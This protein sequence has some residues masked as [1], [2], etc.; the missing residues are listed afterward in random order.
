MNLSGGTSASMQL[1]ND[2]KIKVDERVVVSEDIRITFASFNVNLR[3]I[4]VVSLELALLEI[5]HPV[6]LR[7]VA[8]SLITTKEL[9]LKDH[10]VDADAGNFMTS[11]AR[12]I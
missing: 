8:I 10:C 6:I 4:I 11:V 3:E 2:V 12:T 5:L 1:L 7:S 9:C